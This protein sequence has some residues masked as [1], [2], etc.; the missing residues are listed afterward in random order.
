MGTF[1]RLEMLTQPSNQRLKRHTQPR[2]APFIVIEGA[3]SLGKAL[4]AEGVAVW[5]TKRGFAVQKLSCP[6]NQTQ[7]GRF[8]NELCVTRFLCPP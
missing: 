6:N 1:K 7:L 8:L 3:D 5:L 2:T 4:H